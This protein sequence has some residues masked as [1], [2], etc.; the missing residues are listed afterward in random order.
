MTVAVAG[1]GAVS[2]A[3]CDPAT[4]WNTYLE[5]KARW[6]RDAETGLPVYAIDQLPRVEAIDDFVAGRN[7]DR[8]SLLALHAARQAI[9][10]A[11]WAGDRSFSVLVG[12]SRGPTQA[13]ENAYA[14]YAATG[15]PPLR[16]SPDTTLGSIGFALAD[17]FGV[18]GLAS[19]LSVT[20]S[21]GFHALLHGI[22]LLEAGMVERVLVG[23]TEAS[24]SPFT[25]RQLEVL[26]VYA[27]PTNQEPFACRPLASPASGMVIGEGAAFFALERRSLA[28]KPRITGLGFGR[29]GGH[30]STG[31]SREGDA[32]QSTMRTALGNLGGGPDV[33]V[34]H[35][36][37]T[38]RG[39]AAERAA[40][41]A[42]FPDHP[43]TITSLK[44]ATGHTFGASGPLG[45][46]AALQMLG[47]GR[48]LGQPY[49]PPL[50]DQ[51]PRS[52][53]VNATGF[54]GNAVS[55][56]VQGPA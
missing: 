1:A 2:A 50:P 47:Q 43:P 31:I 19:G 55:V 25:L 18:A 10:A 40:M 49:E 44:W 34:A 52:I 24:L 26:R 48:I 3:G 45:L 4:Q 35:A 30:G 9:A 20:C 46:F 13:W 12:C 54:G 32:L 14:T 56:L 23:G 53:L 15:T 42:L 28:G 38:K 41:A 36:P 17:F 5:G 27:D 8:S 29:E 51:A 21:S 7:V 6:T 11:G 33:V 16:S 22:A 37:G 39:D